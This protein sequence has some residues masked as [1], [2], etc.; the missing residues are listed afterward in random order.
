MYDHPVSV[1]SEKTKP[2]NDDDDDDDHF[3]FQNVL[4]TAPSCLRV[5]VF[6]AFYT[7]GLGFH[8]LTLFLT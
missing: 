3:V 4:K 5:W 7:K 2:D 6:F 8:K 1:M